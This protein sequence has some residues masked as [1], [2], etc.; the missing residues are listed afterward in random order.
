M[1]LDTL[2]RYNRGCVWGL[3]VN[4]DFGRQF[5]VTSEMV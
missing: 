4:H 5:G 3:S 1:K 2:V